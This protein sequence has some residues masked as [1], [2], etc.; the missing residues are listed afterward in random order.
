MLV[1]SSSHLAYRRTSD[2]SAAR[3][4]ASRPDSFTSRHRKEKT[5]RRHAATQASLERA[6]APACETLLRI[7]QQAASKPAQ[8]KSGVPL[9]LS[10]PAAGAESLPQCSPTRDLGEWP[11]RNTEW[12]NAKC[13]TDGIQSSDALSRGIRRQETLLSCA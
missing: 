2:T 9:V 10:W 7:S 12:W 1:P 4:A 8:G 3:S 6:R 11:Q 5:S 13:C